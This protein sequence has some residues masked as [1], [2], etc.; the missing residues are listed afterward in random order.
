MSLIKIF[1]LKRE[2][3]S[4]FEEETSVLETKNMFLFGP[5]LKTE[6]NRRFQTVTCLDYEMHDHIMTT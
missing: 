4:V 6:M 5:T 2:M 1:L 3:E